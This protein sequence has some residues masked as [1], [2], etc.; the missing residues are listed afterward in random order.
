[1]SYITDAAAVAVSMSMVLP[2]Y[3]SWVVM[4]IG[5]AIVVYQYFKLNQTPHTS[6]FIMILAAI[7]VA[8]SQAHSMKRFK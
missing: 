6:I 3:Y 2:P 1:M 5:A 8:L 4:M 7:F